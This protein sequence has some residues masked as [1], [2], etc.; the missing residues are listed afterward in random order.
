MQLAVFVGTKQAATMTLLKKKQNVQVNTIN[1]RWL[2]GTTRGD[3]QKHCCS[4]EEIKRM[5]EEG[6]FDVLPKKVALLGTNQRARLEKFLGDI[7]HALVSRCN[8]RS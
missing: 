6:I 2:G 1:H 7:E 3:Y 8:V 4:F 5:E